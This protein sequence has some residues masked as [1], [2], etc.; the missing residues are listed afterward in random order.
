M[1]KFNYYF[2]E[3]ETKLKHVHF[4]GTRANDHPGFG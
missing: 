2:I 4:V 3:Q 1:L